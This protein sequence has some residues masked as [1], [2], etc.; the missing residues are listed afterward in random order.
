MKEKTTNQ[1]IKIISNS[2]ESNNIPNRVSGNSPINNIVN[3]I[4]AY[5]ANLNDGL[6]LTNQWES[7]VPFA[8][9]TI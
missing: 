1:G 9:L 8:Y 7:F 5:N 3:V 6:L 4:C 2:F